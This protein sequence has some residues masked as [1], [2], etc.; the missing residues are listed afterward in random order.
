MLRESLRQHGNPIFD[1]IENIKLELPEIEIYT[2][3]KTYYF[4]FTKSF[5]VNA[6]RQFYRFVFSFVWFV[7]E[8]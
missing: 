1:F 4:T 6:I 2:K 5:H 7:N 8:T 3:C